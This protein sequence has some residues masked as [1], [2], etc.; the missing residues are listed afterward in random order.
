[1]A[2]TIDSQRAALV[3]YDMTATLLDGPGTEPWIVEDL[4]LLVK[5]LASC[6]EAGVLVCYANSAQGYAGFEIP[7]DI[8]PLS[9]ETRVLHTESGAFSGTNLE[10]LLRDRNVDTVMIA[11][12]AVDRGCNMTARQALNL[13]FKVV[14]VRGACYTHSIVESPFGPLDKHEIERVHLAALFRMGAAVP[15]IEEIMNQLHS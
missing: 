15:T 5:L 1:M 12:M 9:D 8:A 2:D 14:M 7:A 13:G 6:R 4:P 3:I 10:Q 11:G